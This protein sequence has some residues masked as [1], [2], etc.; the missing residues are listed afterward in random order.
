MTPDDRWPAN[1]F[2]DF[3]S[4]SITNFEVIQTTGTNEGPRSPGAP[5]ANAGPDQSVVVGAP[6]QLQGAVSFTGALLAIQW[7]RYS[8][9][10][11]VTFGNP[12]QT[13]T[14]AT[15]NAPG[16]YTLLLSADDGI[17]AVAYDAVVMTASQGILLTVS[18]AG[19]NVNLNWTG[20]SPPY[21]LQQAGALPASTWSGVATTSLQSATLPIA[22]NS[23]S[24]FRVQGQ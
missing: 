17:H 6:A 21:V 15:F 19:T 16:V 9:P 20:A 23:N 12:A 2:A 5:V 4:I 10:G 1:C 3:T 18:G 14:T 8:G 22:T 24:F 7:T 11:A 13:N